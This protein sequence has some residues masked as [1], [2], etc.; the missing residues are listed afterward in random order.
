M[1]MDMSLKA[2]THETFDILSA[3]LLKKPAPK[4]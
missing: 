3:G 2:T 4:P 1:Y